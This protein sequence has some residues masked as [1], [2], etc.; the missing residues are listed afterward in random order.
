MI[1][2]VINFQHFLNFQNMRLLCNNTF[3]IGQIPPYLRIYIAT[4]A[5]INN[6]ICH[7][8]KKLLYLPSN[9]S[10]YIVF[11]YVY[12]FPLQGFSIG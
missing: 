5:V 11:L 9:I 2:N 6:F 3:N 8:F 1:N 12:R 10:T 7:P 4:L